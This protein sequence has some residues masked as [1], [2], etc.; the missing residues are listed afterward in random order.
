M[1]HYVPNLL[2]IITEVVWVAEKCCVASE[3]LPLI[4]AAQRRWT[5]SSCAAGK[6]FA[7]FSI[8]LTLSGLEVGFGIIC[9]T[10]F[11]TIRLSL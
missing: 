9:D 8:F 7:M 5:D 1:S 11:Q 2:E 3:T 4:Y 6:N 10:K